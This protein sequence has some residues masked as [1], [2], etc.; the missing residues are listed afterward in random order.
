MNPLKDE[1]FHSKEKGCVMRNS[2]QKSRDGNFMFL[3]KRCSTH[4]V[5]CCRCGWEWGWHYGTKSPYGKQ[6]NYDTQFKKK[7]K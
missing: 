6:L 4:D 7:W 3:S 2:K 1:H 5:A